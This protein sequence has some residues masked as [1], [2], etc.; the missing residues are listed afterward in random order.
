MRIASCILALALASSSTCAFSQPPH[1]E[2]IYRSVHSVIKNPDWAN[3]A[4]E[5][6]RCVHYMPPKSAVIVLNLD[7]EEQGV[8]ELKGRYRCYRFVGRK[9]T[10]M[11]FHQIRRLRLE[12]DA[13][14]P[15]QDTKGARTQAWEEIIRLYL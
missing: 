12:C 1:L 4:L 10:A 3:P 2:S 7:A 5:R 11:H 13:L 9:A 8:A 15:D 6:M 14:P